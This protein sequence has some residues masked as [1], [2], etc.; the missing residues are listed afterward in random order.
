M[1][2]LVT[3]ASGFVGKNLCSQLHNLGYEVF[4]YDRD[5]SH[6]TLKEY[7]RICDSVIHLAGVNRPQDSKEFY[8]GNFGFTETLCHYLQEANNKAPLIISSS[9]QA[10]LDNDYG[11]SKREGE[12]VVLEHGQ[13]NG[14]SVY[15]YRFSNLFG[16]WC[17]PFYNSVVATWCHQIA[18]GETIQINDEN[19]V[20]TLEYIDD[21]VSELIRCINGTPNITEKSDYLCEVPVNETIT[22]GALARLIESF[23][24]SRETLHVPN[25]ADPFTKK[26]YS[27]YL[28]YLPKDQ[29]SYEL[30]S[31]TDERGSFTEFLKSSDRGQVSI[32]VSKPGI[33]KGQ[34]WHHTKNEKFL[35]V[36]GVGCIQFRDIYTE[37]VIEYNVTGT[38]LEVVDIPVGYTH[39]IINTGNEDLITVMWVNEVFDPENADTYYLEV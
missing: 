36:S 6:E 24:A 20:L 35:V 31:H 28:S 21:V 30:L 3:G 10:T 27:T 23:K 25:M 8:E 33:T 16:K 11:K 18:H 38:K 17:R 5:D 9:I 32:N 39:N 14:S 26:L 29:F 37:E 4:M 1:K 15:I 22:L 34:H 2:I 7:T 12:A 13:S 19:V